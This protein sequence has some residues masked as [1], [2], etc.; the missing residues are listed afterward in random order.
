MR[1]RFV[2]A[3]V[4]SLSAATVFTMPAANADDPLHFTSAWCEQTGGS[5][6][7]AYAECYFTW[8]GGTGP[9]TATFQPATAYTDIGAEDVSTGQADISLGCQT[10]RNA[11]VRATLTDATSTVV[12]TA[13]LNCLTETP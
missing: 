12:A 2:S 4:L 9:V 6:Y 11:G 13:V 7:Y 5:Y 8:A 3:A 10:T 1:F